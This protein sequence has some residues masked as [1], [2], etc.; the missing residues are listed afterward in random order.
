M[1]KVLIIILHTLQVTQATSFL[2]AKPKQ[3]WLWLVYT[4]HGHC[5]FV[6]ALHLGRVVSIWMDGRQF[7]QDIPIE[8]NW[9]ELDFSKKDIVIIQSL[10]LVESLS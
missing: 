9:Q 2:E 3:K 5:T 7:K 1:H 6:Y 10:Q 8:S 4:K